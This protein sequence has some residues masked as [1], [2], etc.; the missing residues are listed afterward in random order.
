MKTVSCAVRGAVMS[1]AGWRLREGLV[2]LLFAKVCTLSPGTRSSYSSGKITNMMSQ[3]CD[4]LRWMVRVASA[5][6]CL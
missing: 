1:K 6:T 3:D 2:A 4:R 5:P